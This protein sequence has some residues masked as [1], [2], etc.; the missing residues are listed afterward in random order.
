MMLM[1]SGAASAAR[2]SRCCSVPI[3]EAFFFEQI[4]RRIAGERKLRENHHVRAGFS[5]SPRERQDAFG[6]A[7]K[8]ADG[9]VGLCQGDLHS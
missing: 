2:R 8:I 1:F 7:A 3:E 5:R 6:V 9:A 4:A